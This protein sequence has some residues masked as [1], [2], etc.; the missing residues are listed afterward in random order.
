[1]GNFLQAFTT[2]CTADIVHYRQIH[3]RHSKLL[4]EYT[5]HVV[6]QTVEWKQKFAVKV[7]SAKYNGRSPG[8]GEGGGF[9]TITSMVVVDL[10]FKHEKGYHV[11][12]LQV[13]CQKRKPQIDGYHVLLFK[14]VCQKLEATN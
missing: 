1:M 7:C 13:V 8:L 3:C 9:R 2:I 12:L 14:V 4:A 11:F 6:L 5:T 10:T